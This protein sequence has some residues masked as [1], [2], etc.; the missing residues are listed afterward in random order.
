M[1][2]RGGQ[3][4]ERNRGMHVAREEGGGGYVTL[5]FRSASRERVCDSY[6]QEREGLEERGRGRRMKKQE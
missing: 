4:N 1:R 6:R 3:M 2:G 5:R